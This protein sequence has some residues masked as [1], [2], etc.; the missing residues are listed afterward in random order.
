MRIK[1]IFLSVVSLGVLVPAS[2]AAQDDEALVYT[3]VY[4]EDFD[5]SLY[6]TG[7]ND[8]IWGSTVLKA[9]YQDDRTDRLG[10][11]FD[12]SNTRT[13]NLCVLL[14]DVFQHSTGS[15]SIT[16]IPLGGVPGFFTARLGLYQFGT[17][18]TSLV[19]SA[20]KFEVAGTEHK[21]S[22]YPGRFS[23]VKL[24]QGMT[25]K[26]LAEI[27]IS[28]GI[29]GRPLFLDQLCLYKRYSVSSGA[30]STARH[31]ILTG[32]FSHEDYTSLQEQLLSNTSVT[33]VDVADATFDDGPVLLE[34]GNPN[35]LFYDSN[36]TPLLQN[37]V[38]LVRGGK[39]ENLVLREGYPFSNFKSFTA[40]NVSYDRRF[41]PGRWSTLCLPFTV[42]DVP[43]VSSVCSLTGYDAS[44][45]E[46]TFS[47]S[48]SLTSSKPRVIRTSVS[49]PF[50]D[51]RGVNAEVKGSGPWRMI[52]SD[53]NLYY[54][55]LYERQE[56]LASTPDVYIYGL[57]ENAFRL[58]GSDNVF[59]SFHCYL[60]VSSSVLPGGS[61]PSRISSN[62]SGD[63]TGLPSLLPDMDEAVTVYS[64]S[65][66]VVRR[67][68][69]APEA[70]LGLPS[71]IYIINHQRYIVQ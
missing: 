15:V 26:E 5:W 50:L 8:N 36:A 41:V 21:G 38:N 4:V 42:R 19:S 28:T 47:P 32:R 70:L 39:C 17:S 40:V 14:G 46:L 1:E 51:L 62:L 68:V 24:R 30:A 23:Y 18:D 44:T 35:C 56:Q 60:R 49:Q 3:S 71:G 2:L 63:P 7:G 10:V 11:H 59:D 37:T 29:E 57:T 31:I 55:G 27:K 64:V 34:T 9:P 69:P 48:V 13:S 33:V 54:S 66:S 12:F 45:G 20:V 22:L 52:L 6:P 61:V 58:S 53:G 67:G 16:G 43:G 25:F 65:G